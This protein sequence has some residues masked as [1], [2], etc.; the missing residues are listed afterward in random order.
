MTIAVCF[1]NFGPYHLA[2]LRALSARLGERGDRLIAYEVAGSERTYPWMRNRRDEPF[3]WITL[4]PERVLETRSSRRPPCRQEAMVGA[5][6]SRSSRRPVC[7]RLFA[8]GIDGR[9]AL[10]ETA[11]PAGDPDVREPGNRSPAVLVERTGQ[12]ISTGWLFDVTRSSVG[13]GTSTTLC[14]WECLATEWPWAI[15]QS[16]TPISRPD[17]GP[18]ARPPTAARD[19]PLLPIS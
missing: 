13:A 16:T 12:E 9:G 8:A 6:R 5:A 18:G 11:R 14:D 1:T 2:R 15:T 3:E 7:R 19:C 17:P 10:G 4:F